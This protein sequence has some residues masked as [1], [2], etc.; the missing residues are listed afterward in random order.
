MDQVVIVINPG[1]TSTKMALFCGEKR[2]AQEAVSHPADELRV[3]EN[4]ADQFNLRMK[5]I[6]DWL[7]AQGI[8]QKKVVAVAGRGARLRPL[9]S[10]IYR[11]NENMLN[12]LRTMRY[13]NHAGNL[14]A[15]I[16]DHLGR[17]YNVPAIIVDPITLDD[18]PEIAKISGVPEIERVC[19]SHALNIREVSRLE[20]QKLG[21]KLEQCNFVT[22]HMGGG[23]S[24]AAVAHG[25]IVDVNDAL[26]GMGPFSVERA[27]AVPIGALVKMAFSGKYTEQQLIHKLSHES[28]LKGY[29]GE[30]D[31]RKVEQMIDDGDEKAALYYGAMIYQIARE[32]C[33]M[34]VV[35]K[36]RFERIIL[37]GGMAKSERLVAALKEYIA[38]LGD[39]AVVPGEFEMEA[40]AAGAV[41]VLDG[42]ETPNDY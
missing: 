19:R 32:I 11:I 28:G 14:G 5:N 42:S 16:A 25:R 34:T 26:L 2:L 38:F 12:D 40:L 33:A 27:G 41:R 36:G 31:L 3:F 8:E 13:S 20:A 21:K 22:V 15:I 4:V 30:N 23:I 24:V 37:T 1:S 17:R 10:G 9:K 18:F 29:L 35:L 6:D 7:T 39:I